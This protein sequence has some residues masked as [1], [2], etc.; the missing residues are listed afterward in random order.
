VELVS[1]NVNVE[2]VEA[3]LDSHAEKWGPMLIVKAGEEYFA[4]ANCSS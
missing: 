2:E 4:G 3:W 1:A